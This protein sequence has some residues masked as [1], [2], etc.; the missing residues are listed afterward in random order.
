MNE[1]LYNEVIDAVAKQGYVVIEN[2]LDIALLEEL[3]S[4]A[5]S[6]TR[7]KSAGI[8][9]SAALRVDKTRRSDKTLW[10][11]EDGGV[12]SNYLSFANGLR[13]AV[14][15]TLYMGLS[16]YEA[17][18]ALYE[19]GDFYEKHLDAFRGSKNRV[20][21]TVLYLNE[22]WSEADGGSLCIYDAEDNL[23]Q[24]VLPKMGTLVVFLSDKFPHEVLLAKK[25]RYSIAGWFRVDRRE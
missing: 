4:Y 25:E 3:V 14:N 8:S 16:Y 13:E 20:L 15:R 2:A 18:F 10:L 23:V 19:A 7:Y 17:H 21:T 1:K 6:A 12:Q 22:A 11:E 5:K 9:S 24:K